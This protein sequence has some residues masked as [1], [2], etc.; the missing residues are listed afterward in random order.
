MT[1]ETTKNS[2]YFDVTAAALA[3]ITLAPIESINRE[4]EEANIVPAEGT[5]DTDR[6]VTFLK[7]QG[8]ASQG[9]YAAIVV[10]MT[11]GE[12]VP[13]DPAQLT[14]AL[15]AAFPNAG[16]SK[17]H[18]P[19]YLSHARHG[20]LKGLREDLK[21]I[22][23]ARRKAKVKT[24]SDLDI[25]ADAPAITIALLM[26]ENDQETLVE[27]AK[28]MGIKATMKW[29]VE[30]VAQKIVDFMAPKADEADESAAA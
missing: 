24:E 6:A 4:L 28:G 10:N 13:L 27:M 30:T 20:R 29:K 23:H 5:D 18:G 1:T 26:A 9:H 22:P 25:A 7:T 19:H 11:H 17:R 2:R 14:I 12:G 16:V 15:T 3:L 21:P 8:I